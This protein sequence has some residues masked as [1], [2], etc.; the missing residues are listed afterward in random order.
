VGARRRTAVLALFALVVFSIEAGTVLA[1]GG[2]LPGSSDRIVPRAAA[3]VAVAPGSKVIVGHSY[4]NDTSPALRTMKRALPSYSAEHEANK[5]PAIASRHKDAIDT[6]RQSKQY[7]PNMPAPIQ[8]FDGIP[9]PGV[10]CDC[11][12]PDTNG[13]VGLTQYVQIVNEGFQVFDKTTGSSL[14]GPVGITSLWAGFGGVCQTDGE[15]DPVVL[16]DQLANR[17]L[18]TQFAGTDQPTDECIAVSTT[19]DAAGSY[20]RY[21][22]HLGSDFFDYP[23][24]GVWPDAYYMSTNVFNASGTAF[25]GPQPFGFDRAAMLAGN[26]ATFVTTRDPSV[27]SPTNDAM[28]PADLDG[29]TLPPAGAPN[30]FYMSGTLAT[31]TVYRYHVDFTTPSN[32]TFTVGGTLTPAP[33]TALCPTTSACVPEPNGSFLDGIGDRPMFRLA[34]RRFADGHEALVGNQSVS[35]GG[36]AGV[37]WWEINHATSGTPA[38]TQ[39]STYQPDTTWRWMG[40]AAMD[41]DGDLAVGFSASSSTVFPSLR[42]AGRLAADPANTLAQGESVLFAGAGS[43]TGTNN[44]WGDYSDLTID[45]VDD[46]TFWYTNEYYPSGS[47]SFNWRTRIGSFK[48]PSCN[49]PDPFVT[50]SKTAD[51]TTISAGDQ[52]GFNV[53]LN[54]AGGATATGLTFTDNLPSAAGVDWT[55]DAA[56]SDAGWSITGSPPNESLTY[57]PTT[58]AAQTLTHVHVVSATSGSTCGTTLNNTASFTTG[59]DGSGNA[60]A[61]ITVL[62]PVATLMSE[63][64]DGVTAPALPAG[65]TATNAT[66]PAPLW[67]TS[68]SGNPAPAADSAPNAA[69]V[70]DPATISD[71]R[72]DSPTIPIASANAQLTFRQ[73]RNLESGFDGGVLEISIDGGAFADIVTAGGSFVTGG[74]NGT[75]STNFSSPIAGRSAWTGSSGGFI[76]TTVKVPAAAAGHNVQFRWRMGSDSSASSQGWRIDN[77]QVTDRACG[78]Q[79]VTIAKTA[80]N[81]SVVAGNQIGYTVTLTNTGGITV[82]GLVVTDSLPAGTGVNWTLDAGG[83]SPGWSVSGSPPTQSLAYSETTLDPGESTHVHVTSSTTTDSCGT[84]NNTASF[85]TSND[86]A[87]ASTAQVEV[88]CANVSITKV[89]DSTSVNSGS[90]A[91]YVVT[92]SNSGGATATGLNVTDNLPAAPGVSWSIDGANTDPG[93]SVSGSPP[94]QSLVYSPTTLAAGASTHVHVVSSTNAATCGSVMNNQA[95]FTTGNDGSGNASASIAVVTGVFAENFDGVTAPALPAGWTAANASGAAPLWTTSSTGLPAPPADSAPN[96]AAVDDPSSV[97]DKRLDSP[98]LPIASANAQLTFR[99]NR[100]LEES[101][102]TP[103]LAFDGG[104]LEIS[105]DGGAFADIVTA[106]GSFV[107]GGYGHTVSTAFTNPIGGR[108]AWS[109]NSN[110]FVTTVVN[111]PAAAAG[112]SIVLRWRMGSDSSVGRDGWRIDN[113]SITDASCTQPPS[114]SITKTADSATVDA[115]SQIGFTVTLANSGGGDAEGLSV[116]DSLPAGSGVNWTIDAA[117]TD[118]GWSVS[119]S[120]PNQSLSY[121]PTTLAAGASTHVHVV[122][123]TGPS[124]CGAYDN[125]ASYTSSNGGSGQASASV[126]VRCAGRGE[127]LDRSTLCQQFADG[128]AVP[129][130]AL[131]Y[132]TQGGNIKKTSPAG[133]MYWVQ[134]TAAAGPSSFTINQSITTG[135]FSKLFYLGGGN[136]VYR[137]NCAK[138][139]SPTITQAPN[140][141][142]TVAFNAPAAGTYYIGLRYASASVNGQPAP[143]PSTVHYEFTTAGITGTTDGLD[144][145]KKLPARPGRPILRAFLRA[146][147][148]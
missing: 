141:A 125:T 59:N 69:F 51:A 72:L 63:N 88:L 133:F 94:S 46:C 144:L 23:K 99:Q 1:G 130:S 32:S 131:E 35:S 142:V 119:G 80:D 31:S 18:I 64:F 8:N 127:I 129:L 49:N 98:S 42:Y 60:S 138:K 126:T 75:I 9:F 122:S 136:N 120:P 34:Y 135:N 89:A 2:V 30:P 5:N 77:V 118:P 117:N 44:R 115:G 67:T 37:R 52:A 56:N 124:S 91:G 57:A 97:S 45:P 10:A 39:E 66:G 29:S 90:Q 116:S 103:G 95:S 14:F 105:I 134:V 22:F 58:I 27:F 3:P 86:G 107:S 26:P 104:V 65:W 33:F 137:S 74:Y 25:L 83:S 78:G 84:Y 92:L 139:L 50:I 55:I 145:Q 53:T 15:G 148:H 54:N 73:N 38:F 13:D 147:R 61:S 4:A 62:G 24:L 81:A 146:L 47:S 48:F 111:L 114:L 17:W 36:V 113:V 41:R 71:K 7:A 100:N 140:G 109:G 76:T 93:W 40:S 87:G 143:T 21:A 132:A 6:V 20:N 11:A 106:G 128:T 102:V 28:L 82:T 70:D 43:Q 121:A 19:S 96:A 85:T 68:S 123:S 112:H 110:G 108:S 79:T 16:Y 101:S 12:P